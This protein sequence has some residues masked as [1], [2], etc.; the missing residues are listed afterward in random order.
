[1]T[2]DN[3]G[4]LFKNDRKEKETHPDY[5][6]S[7]TIN[8]VEHWLSGWKKQGKKGTFLSLSIGEPKQ[9]QESPSQVNHGSQGDD[10]DDDDI[11]F[12]QAVS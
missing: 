3:S 2:Y 12:N 4:I 8:G 1:M 6:G 11:P 7:I 5:K 10:F 9:E